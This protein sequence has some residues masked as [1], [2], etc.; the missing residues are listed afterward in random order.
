L[1]QY[2]QTENSTHSRINRGDVHQPERSRCDLTRRINSRDVVVGTRPLKGRVGDD[3]ARGIT[4]DRGEL[5][6]VSG[7]QANLRSGDVDPGLR[8]KLRK[9]GTENRRKYK[10]AHGSSEDFVDRREVT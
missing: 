6:Y 1:R 8:P 10:R 9:S 5:R 3:V 7:G 4:R 2:L